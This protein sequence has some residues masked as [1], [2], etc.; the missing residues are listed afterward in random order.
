V[1][2]GCGGVVARLS[3]YLLPCACFAVSCMGVACDGLPQ[4][5]HCA[6][7]MQQQTRETRR[8]RERS[9]VFCGGAQLR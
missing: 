6:S 4:Q 8:P 9:V 2:D 5:W 1:K 7:L 3:T